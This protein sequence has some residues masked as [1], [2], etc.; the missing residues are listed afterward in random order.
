[1]KKR[2][3]GFM[4]AAVC[5]TNGIVQAADELTPQVDELLG[6]YVG[7]GYFH[8]AVLVARDGRV[9]VSKIYGM[10]NIER[11]TPKTPQTRFLIGDAPPDEMSCGWTGDGYHPLQK[12][13]EVVQGPHTQTSLVQV[14]AKH[15]VPPTW[16]D[17][18]RVRLRQARRR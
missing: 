16:T 5:I 18:R 6:R 17:I 9:L 7:T 10:A 13:R 4:L 2:I 11:E 3:V 8:G 15:A 1:M 14:L 12:I